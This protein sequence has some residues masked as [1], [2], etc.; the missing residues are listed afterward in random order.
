MIRW[1]V[2]LI[3]EIQDSLDFRICIYACMYI[4]FCLQ[5]RQNILQYSRQDFVQEVL[6]VVWF[7]VFTVEGE[8]IRLTSIIFHS[9][10]LC[11]LL[12]RDRH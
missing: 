11:C 9:V 6:F 12:R 5:C 10:I 8:L 3:I 7:I 1:E 2:G 4:E